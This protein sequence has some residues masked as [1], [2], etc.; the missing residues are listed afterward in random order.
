M[1]RTSLGVAGALVVAALVGL[2]FAPPASATRYEIDI[3]KV[4]RGYT[5]HVVGYIDVDEQARTGTGHLHVGVTDPAGKV[6]FERDYDFSFS[7][8]SI[9][10]PITFIV[11]G[12]NLLVTISFSDVGVS[13]TARP[14]LNPT[15]IQLRRGRLSA[16]EN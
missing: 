8:S 15:P 1:F 11:S 2:A 4:I 12:A 14:L 6:V 5:I 10:R 9:P 7:W 13:V 16:L 3:T